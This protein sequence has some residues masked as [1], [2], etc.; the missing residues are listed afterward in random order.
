MLQEGTLSNDHRRFWGLAFFMHWMLFSAE[1]GTLWHRNLM[2]CIIYHTWVMTTAET[3]G[4]GPA[5]QVLQ[6]SAWSHKSYTK[7]CL[8]GGGEVGGMSWEGGG[9]G[10]REREGGRF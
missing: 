9:R 7:E 1:S 6:F 3:A 2:Q 8:E 10:L 5:A 4:E